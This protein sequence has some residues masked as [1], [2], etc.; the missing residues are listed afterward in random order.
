MLSVASTQVFGAVCAHVEVYA[1][2]SKAA[3]IWLYV[4]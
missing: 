2:T 4:Q 3:S 1:Q